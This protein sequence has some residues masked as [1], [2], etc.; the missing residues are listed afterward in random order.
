[1]KTPSCW[2]G[3]LL[4]ESG[5]RSDTAACPVRNPRF[6]ANPRIH[7]Y[8]PNSMLPASPD[9]T[10]VENRSLRRFH[11][12]PP[13][14]QK[15]PC[16]C[17]PRQVRY[18]PSFA[19][20]AHAVPFSLVTRPQ[21]RIHGVNRSVPPKKTVQKIQNSCPGSEYAPRKLPEQKSASE[22]TELPRTLVCAVAN[23]A[24]CTLYAR[25]SA[26]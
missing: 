2:S 8:P 24:S 13:R 19:L 10:R 20:A 23:F 25:Q 3:R 17:D 12:L 26:A 5:G 22:G 7:L 16:P 18:P 6:S 14:Q 4:Q 15:Q 11:S 9:Q 1:M 21:F